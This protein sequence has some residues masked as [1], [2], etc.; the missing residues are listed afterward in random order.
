MPSGTWAR[1]PR[2]IP[3]CCPIWKNIVYPVKTAFV[4]N[5]GPFC[6]F[7]PQAVFGL[8]DFHQFFGQSNL[9]LGRATP[10]YRS[11]GPRRPKCHIIPDAVILA[12]SSRPGLCRPWP[13]PT[14]YLV[15]AAVEQGVAPA[16]H[17]ESKGSGPG[18]GLGREDINVGISLIALFGVTQGGV[19]KRDRPPNIRSQ[20]WLRPSTSGDCR[21]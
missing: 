11:C 4:P 15:G 8:V 17:R 21:P 14:V 6:R 10:H 12:S 20:S 3:R 2:L 9:F 5:P 1:T 7:E 13:L 19:A 16:P 18:H